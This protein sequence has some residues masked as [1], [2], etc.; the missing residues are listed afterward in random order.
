M[1]AAAAGSG[2]GDG[3]SPASLSSADSTAT[4]FARCRHRN[5]DRAVLRSVASCVE[6]PEQTA[7]RWWHGS[8]VTPRSD[9]CSGRSLEGVEGAAAAAGGSVCS[10]CGAVRSLQEHGSLPGDVVVRPRRRR[11]RRLC[12]P[13]RSL[14][15]KRRCYVVVVVVVVV[16]AAVVT[17]GRGTF[18]SWATVPRNC[19]CRRRRF[20]SSRCHRPI[21]RPHQ[22]LRPRVE[23]ARVSRRPDR[24]CNDAASA[25][26]GR[27]RRT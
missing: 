19:A 4:G 8:P 5:R 10:W 15:S 7:R 24:S 18:F 14:G 1:A 20:D 16:T 26:G 6:R 21:G 9:H 27:E 11:L 25:G 3:T 17:T 22:W 2:G 12:R 23:R 13:S